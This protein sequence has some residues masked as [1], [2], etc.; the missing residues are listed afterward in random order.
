MPLELHRF[1]VRATLREL[2]S[3]ELREGAEPTPDD[4]VLADYR[5]RSTSPVG[6]PSGS[7]RFPAWSST[8]SSS[9]ALVSEVLI[10]RDGEVERLAP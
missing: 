5:G 3:A 1:G 9:P 6:S 10:G 7:G 4:G 2:G 8:D